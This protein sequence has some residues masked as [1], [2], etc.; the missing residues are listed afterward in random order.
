MFIYRGIEVVPTGRKG[1]KYDKQRTKVIHTLI[2]VKPLKVE[3]HEDDW[4]EWVA[5]T[6]LYEIQVTQP[7]TDPTLLLES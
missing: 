4:M 2:E 6:D 5:R 7:K 1:V 3:E